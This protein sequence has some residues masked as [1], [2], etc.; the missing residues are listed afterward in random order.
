M[1]NRGSAVDLR[2]TARMLPAGTSS[3]PIECHSFVLGVPQPVCDFFGLEGP[4]FEFEVTIERLGNF[5]CGARFPDL[6]Q[7]SRNGRFE[8]T[9]I[10][11][12]AHFR[13]QLSN[14]TLAYSDRGPMSGWVW[15]GCKPECK[16]W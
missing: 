8:T 7:R 5:F 3:W 13:F 9:G 1:P 15:I 4:V 12:L 2:K 10:R 6:V 11:P 14:M 16:S